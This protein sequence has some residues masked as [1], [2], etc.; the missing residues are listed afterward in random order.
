MSSNLS[1]LNKTATSIEFKEQRYKLEV[2]SLIIHLLFYL[3]SKRKCSG[4]G[5][6]SGNFSYTVFGS[7]C[8]ILNLFK[9]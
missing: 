6:G 1:C 8:V 5:S 3:F 4:S 2:N 9:S 7:K